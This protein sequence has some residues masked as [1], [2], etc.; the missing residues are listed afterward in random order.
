MAFELDDP[1]AQLPFTARLAREQA[2]SHVFAGRV[3]TEYKRFVVLAMLAGHPVT[4]SEEVDQAWHLHL[5]YT[6]SYWHGLC[7]DVLGRDL[8]HGPTAG[9]S[10]ENTK[11]NDWYEKTL[12]SYLRIFEQAAPSDIWP[13]PKLRFADAGAGRWVNTAKFWLVSKP[14]FMKYFSGKP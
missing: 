1:D 3:I 5:V 7:R 10:N 9:G 4:P 8:H 2:W 13:P 14:G 11:Y 12:E 6:R